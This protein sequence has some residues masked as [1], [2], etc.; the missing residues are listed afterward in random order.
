MSSAV[1]STN[2]Y[3]GKRFVSSTFPRSVSTYE[4]PTMAKHQNANFFQFDICQSL[5][6]LLLLTFIARNRNRAD[7]SFFAAKEISKIM[8]K[9]AECDAPALVKT[10]C[11]FY[12]SHLL[13]HWSRT[14]QVALSRQKLSCTVFCH[15]A[16]ERLSLRNTVK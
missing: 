8:S 1:S 7:L 5:D 6:W 2:L 13:T 10:I 12:G 4:G 3:R 16:T 9:S 14:Q 15:C 11:I